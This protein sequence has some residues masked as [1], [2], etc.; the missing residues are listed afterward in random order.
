MLERL[1]LSH[2]LLGDNISDCL[3]T[4]ISALPRLLHLGLVSCDLT[5][6]FLQ[7][8]RIKLSNALQ[9][10][11]VQSINLSYNKLG[12]VGV[13]HLLRCL[14]PSSITDL[15]LTGTIQPGSTNHLD[16]T[17]PIQ[18][19]FAKQ[20]CTRNHLAKHLVSYVQHPGCV[21]QNVVLAKCHLTQDHTQD[22]IRLVQKCPSL[23]CLDLNGNAK[24]Y[25]ADVTEIVTAVSKSTDSCIENVNVS[26][27]GMVA[28][29]N[30]D[31]LDAIQDKLNQRIPFRHLVLSC[32]GLSEKDVV[33]LQEIWRTKWAE[34][35]ECHVYAE[36]VTLSVKH[37]E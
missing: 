15:D 26:S 7:H 2:N 32:K 35:A 9:A 22:L 14:K 27:C 5:K 13:E 33:S 4:I 11:A 25:Q 28:P 8:H 6:N 23:R 21:L 34:S 1:E 10:R 29:L 30:I 12:S 19:C 3:P 36:T 20:T 31:L 18:T 17:G 24:L 37:S 16:L